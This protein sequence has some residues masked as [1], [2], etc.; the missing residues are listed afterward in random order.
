LVFFAIYIG[1]ALTT[2]RLLVLQARRNR[3]AA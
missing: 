2:A 1:L 3:A